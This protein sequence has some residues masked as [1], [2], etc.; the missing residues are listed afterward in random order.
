MRVRQGRGGIEKGR[1]VAVVVAVDCSL[2]SWVSCWTRGVD[3]EAWKIVRR[4]TLARGTQ[5]PR[6]TV[7]YV[8][9]S[10]MYL[11][12]ES[13]YYVRTARVALHKLPGINARTGWALS[14]PPSNERRR[15]QGNLPDVGL[16]LCKVLPVSLHPSPLTLKNESQTGFLSRHARSKLLNTSAQLLL[17]T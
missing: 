14:W 5:V 4:V 10:T 16:F 13:R 11:L 3:P 2:N 7:L 9:R 17:P 1:E 6:S 8:L 15:F 12:K